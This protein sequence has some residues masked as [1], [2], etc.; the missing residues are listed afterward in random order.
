MKVM[1]RGRFRLTCRTIVLLLLGVATGFTRAAESNYLVAVAVDAKGQVLVGD[2]GTKAVYR[3]VDG[4]KELVVQG[5][6]KPRTPLYALRGLAVDGQGGILVADPATCDVH[7]VA[8][9]GTLS[10]LSKGS[11]NQPYGVALGR[12]G[13]VFVADLGE[14]AV[15]QIKDGQ[16]EKYADVDN[17]AALALEKDGSLIVVSRGTNNLYRVSPDRKVSV[18]VQGRKLKFPHAVVVEN[19]GSYLVSDGYGKCIWRVSAKGDAAVF[20]TSDSFKSPQGLAFE[21]NGNLLVAD[22]QAQAVFRVTAD[23]KASVCFKP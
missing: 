2:A 13:E 5:A 11:L 6:G 21:A 3:V 17:P 15:F 16:A 20:A 18:V 19:S 4:K 12:K 9:D 8:A 7:R 23:G 22:P 10:S 14:K 1:I